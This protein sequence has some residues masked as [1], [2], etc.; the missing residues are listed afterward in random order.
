MQMKLRRVGSKNR[1]VEM[2]REE[3]GSHSEDLAFYFQCDVSP[4]EEEMATQ[5]NIFA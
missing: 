1:V 4:M 2:D 5:S 3:C